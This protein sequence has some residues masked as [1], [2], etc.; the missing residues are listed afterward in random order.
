MTQA[1]SEL[2]APSV[3]IITGLSGAGRSEAAHALEDMGYFVVD[4]MPPALI[5]KM[6]ELASSPGQER[7]RIALVADVRGG[8]YFEALSEAIKELAERGID[9]R[10][11]FLTASDE[12]LIRRYELERR[13][14][15]LADRI[16]DGISKE[17]AMLR[18]LREDADLVIDTS[19]LN[20]H[21][22]RQRIVSMFGAGARDKQMRTTVVSFGYKHGLP[23]DA[24]MVL[25]CRYLPNPHWVEELR[26]LPG[27]DAKI[28]EYVLGKEETQDFLERVR[29]LFDG[30][31]PG[32]VREGKRYLTIA[33]GCT[34]GRHRS[35][36]LADEL[37][38]ML[39]AHGV[40][41]Q[42]THRDLERE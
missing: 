25:D 15:P 34:G 40:P 2:E 37:G 30:L 38:E 33:I 36:V 17:R 35:V 14:H 32:F 9:H 27:S 19:T 31:V 13:T 6:L 41:V 22:L 1:E 4:N 23:V 42:V 7:D 16:I 21:Q 8:A 20:V 24:D 28:R 26:P 12:A 5:G 18:S 3:T 11:V 29:T 10:I 39:R